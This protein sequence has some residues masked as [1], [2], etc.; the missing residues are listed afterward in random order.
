MRVSL[1]VALLSPSVGFRTSIKKQR[2]LQPYTAQAADCIC[3]FDVDRTLTAK[4]GIDQ[5]QQC[6]G[7]QNHSDIVDFAY[8]GG[9]LIQSEMAVQLRDS[10]CGQCYFGI[11]SAGTASGP[12][13]ANRA[14]VDTLVAEQYNVGGWVDDCPSPVDGTKVTAC[15]EGAKQHAVADI[16]TWLSGQGITIADENVHFFD[17]KQ[18]NIEG[19]VDGPY[20]AHQISCESRD[21]HRGKCGGTFAELV[22]DAGQI[23]CPPAPPAPPAPPLY[24]APACLDSAACHAAHAPPRDP[25]AP[26][27][28]LTETGGFGMSYGPLPTRE[29]GRFPN[30]D[31]MAPWFRAQWAWDGRNDLGVMAQMGANMVRLYGNDP[32]WDAHEFLDTANSWGI[33]VVAGISDHPYTEGDNKCIRGRDTSHFDCYEA[34]KETWETRL[35]NGTFMLEEGGYH[36]ALDA[37]VVI[38]EPDLKLINRDRSV[39][40]V[41]PQYMKVVLSAIDGILAAELEQGI[42][43]TSSETIKLTAPF[44]YSPGLD[45]PNLHKLKEYGLECCVQCHEPDETYGNGEPMYPQCSA[46]SGN[47][48]LPIEQGGMKCGRRRLTNMRDE[49]PALPMIVDFYEAILDPSSVGYTFR[50][51]GWREAIQN[52][53]VHSFNG[54]IKAWIM[55][56]QFLV[57]Y[58]QL[59]FNKDR[60]ASEMV[61][62]FMGEYGDK[63]VARDLE[64]SAED[65]EQAMALVR[66]RTNPFYAFNYFEF[67]VSYWK[68][69][70]EDAQEA[71]D[72]WVDEHWA[73]REGYPGHCDERLHG[74]FGYG[75]IPVSRSGRVDTGNEDEWPIF[76]IPCLYSVFDGKAETIAAAFGGTAPDTTLCRGGWESGAKQ[77]CVASRSM[78]WETGG[79]VGW[80]C[81]HLGGMDIDCM[82]DLPDECDDP[83]GR[84]D[85]AFSR[86][87]EMNKAAHT[88]SYAD[89]CSFGGQGIITTMPARPE[90]VHTDYESMPVG[91]PPGSAAVQTTAATTTTVAPTTTVDLNL[92]VCSCSVDGIVNGVNT[93]RPGCE[94]HAGA[95]WGKFCYIEGNHNQC[96]TARHSPGLGLYFRSC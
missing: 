17:D 59:P 31:M 38:N 93:H 77:Y 28:P 21:G 65:L 57:K 67:S 47:A 69:C 12:D 25:L 84:A 35:T 75:P 46:L 73:D 24:L 87:F 14:L 82:Q 36:P 81:G 56:Q 33:K 20:N 91:W 80:V 34:L 54:F 8:D 94:A 53:F 1:F 95:R 9:T 78:I 61:P 72:G 37:L 63:N 19:F 4:Q 50:T 68:Q 90:C 79:G 22:N 45:S 13:S 71:W 39:R 2:D 3:I 32:R 15:G 49:C 40:G 64:M 52:R 7:V 85:W 6:T 11:V 43:I 58:V 60:E 51:E 10:F 74:T 48:G 42:D 66:D 55:E 89:I 62:V 83:Y 44:S 41:D 92:Y 70:N 5:I 23:F 26:T 96:P 86:F 16:L 88:G 30:D 18:N 76:D 27:R 29:V